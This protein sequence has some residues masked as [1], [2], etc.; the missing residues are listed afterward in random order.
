M[1]QLF[2][3]L[4]TPKYPFV[5]QAAIAAAKSTPHSVSA[6]PSPGGAPHSKKLR[7][8]KRFHPSD[9]PMIASVVFEAGFDYIEKPVL[10]S[11]ISP[12]CSSLVFSVHSLRG[13]PSA[14]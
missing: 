1:V 2:F 9:A 5:P 12:Y 4:D 13:P 10:G 8:N 3:N 14:A 11:Y 7:L 6:D